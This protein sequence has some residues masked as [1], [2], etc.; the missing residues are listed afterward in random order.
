MNSSVT[1]ATATLIDWDTLD[2]RTNSMSDIDVCQIIDS[3]S[4][5]AGVKSFHFLDDS[6]QSMLINLKK[7][8]VTL[9]QITRYLWL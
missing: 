9:D 4:Q 8:M 3:Y 6:Q 5:S 7:R 1:D 2:L